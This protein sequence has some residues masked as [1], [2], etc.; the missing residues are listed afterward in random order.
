M[1]ISWGILLFI[2]VIVWIGRHCKKDP[3]SPIC[4]L[5]EIDLQVALKILVVFALVI[6]LAKLIASFIKK[7]APMTLRDSP[8]L[9]HRKEVILDGVVEHIFENTVFEV[10]KRKATDTFRNF[11]GNE[12]SKGRYIHLRFLLSSKNLRRGERILVEHNLD[13]G[14]IPLRVGSKV[15]VRGEYLH[16]DSNIE[17]RNFY[18]KI[19]FTHAPR[20][21]IEI[22]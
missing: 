13:Y 3:L 9:F 17:R 18:G 5:R 10:A 8:G 4:S 19:H 6:F 12:D 1:L 7:S 11:S 21:F 16:P 2:G 14:E 15:R 20:G 22:I